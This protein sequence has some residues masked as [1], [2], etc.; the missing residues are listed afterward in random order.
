MDWTDNRQGGRRHKWLCHGTNKR[1]FLV[2]ACPVTPIL[3]SFQ[4]KE[5]EEE[6]HRKNRV[7]NLT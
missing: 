7:V 1:F 3:P 6:K 4:S 2:Q 5:E